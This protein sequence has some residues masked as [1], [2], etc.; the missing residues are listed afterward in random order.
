VLVVLRQSTHIL[1]NLPDSLWEVEKGMRC[2]ENNYNYVA[3]YYQFAKLKHL[4]LL[5]THS[6]ITREFP[7]ALIAI[8]ITLAITISIYYKY[9]YSSGPYFR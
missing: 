6:F 9:A 8:T 4:Q 7:E 1:P 2:T 5:G 3:I